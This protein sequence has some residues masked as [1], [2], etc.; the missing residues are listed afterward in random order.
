[1]NKKIWTSSY[2]VVTTG[3]AI[4]VLATMIY[5]IEVKGARGWWSR[6]FDVFGKNPLFIF[7]LSGFLPRILALIRIPNTPGADG[8]PRYLSPFGWFYENI[9]AKV[10]GVP[11]NGSLVY[12]ICM[13]LFYWAIVYWM[14]KRKIYVKV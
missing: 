10:P 11:E 8:K 4:L 13:I 6:F 2:V 7:F 14:D 9:C 5:A 3:L 12:A 1:M